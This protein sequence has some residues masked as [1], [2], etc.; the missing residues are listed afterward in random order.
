[1][2]G[3]AKKVLLA[4]TFGA[5]LADIRLSNID[6]ITAAGTLVLYML[7]IYYDFAGYSDIAI[8]LSRLFGFEFKEN[9]NFPYLSKSI[10]NFGAGGIFL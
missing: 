4:D 9:F 8:G 1:M 3:F 2:I 10:L 5:C 6:P 7:Q